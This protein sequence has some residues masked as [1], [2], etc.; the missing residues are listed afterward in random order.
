MPAKSDRAKRIL[1]PYFLAGSG[2]LVSAR[3]ISAFLLRKRPDWEVRLFEPADEFKSKALDSFF[4]RSWHLVLNRPKLAAMAFTLLDSLLPFIPIAINTAIMRR[5]MPHARN[6]IENYRPDLIVTTHWGCGHLFQSTRLEYGID[7][8]LY[9]VRNDLG[10]AFQIQDCG[11]DL[12]FVMS[13]SARDAFLE[14]GVLEE[15]IRQVNLL[16]RPEFLPDAT[17]KQL[18]RRRIGV[19]DDN[20]VVLI[21]A[22]GEGLGSMEE[23]ARATVDVLGDGGRRLRL[24]VLAGRNSELFDQLN[25]MF[26][27]QRVTV[28]SYQEKMHEV[29]SAA[30]FVVGKCGAN[31]TMESLMMRK[32]FVITQ[33]G[34]PNE[35]FN[36]RFV[37]DN[38][39]GWYAPTTEAYREVLESYLRNDPA[40]REVR[41][42]LEAFPRT[43]GAEQIADVIVNRLEQA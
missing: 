3:A 6:L 43:S 23:Y 10:G 15:R 34:A 12:T 2:H 22:G 31:Y 29:M 32:L 28:L 19:D 35:E 25:G 38:Q 1:I 33:V 21:S 26:T 14:I 40:I 4:R 41:D 7:V 36:M 27:D 11:C 13:E 9:L 37:V 18:A 39:L 42:R 16:V 24:F 20:T 5:E 30:D 8:P 17:S